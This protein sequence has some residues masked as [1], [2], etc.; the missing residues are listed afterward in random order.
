MMPT[1]LRLKTQLS[2]VATLRRIPLIQPRPRPT[3]DNG[4]EDDGTEC[5]QVPADGL[6]ETAVGRGAGQG[7]LNRNGRR[8]WRE[9]G[10]GWGMRRSDM[11]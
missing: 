8:G 1:L 10:R 9:D 6:G 5:G 4:C 2:P 7:A 3:D 11:G